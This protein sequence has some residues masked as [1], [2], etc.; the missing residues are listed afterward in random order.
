[1][2]PSRTLARPSASAARPAVE[3]HQRA[4]SRRR[5][6][7]L[8]G[9]VVKNYEG[10]GAFVLFTALLFA[11]NIGTLAVLVAA[12]VSAGLL[13]AEP[14]LTVEAL[15]DRWPMLLIGLLAV[16]SVFWSQ[17]P[18][19]TLKYSVQA[20]LVL[21][22]G[23][24]LSHSP[25]RDSA[26][27]GT[28]ASFAIY[29]A[30]ALTFGRSVKVG[31]GGEMAFSGLTGS[32]NF[33]A[34]MSVLSMLTSLYM[35]FAPRA[36]PAA[37][38]LKIAAG[39]SFLLAL[40]ALVG[41]HSAGALVGGVAAV[42]L[43]VGL[44]AVSTLGFGARLTAVIAA[45][46]VGALLVTFREAAIAALTDFFATAFHKDST[47]TGRTYL[48]YRAQSIIA[49]RPMLGVGFAAF[50]V[51]G[52]ADPEG[53]WRYT[54]VA[55]RSGITFHNTYI[56]YLVELGLVGLVTFLIGAVTGAVGTLRRYVTEGGAAACFWIVLLEY[57]FARSPIEAVGLEPL[58]FTTVLLYAALGSGFG[59]RSLRGPA[60]VRTARF[61]R[62]A[63]RRPESAPQSSADAR[64]RVRPLR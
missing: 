14:R 52:D 37:P 45:L 30:F 35:L 6:A 18:D 19:E 20:L 43:L 36:G 25:G 62:A 11:P 24:R 13:A 53:L 60:R 5:W 39:I 41:A 48:W 26:L 34:D 46:V 23:L 8:I 15:R 2:R 16:I 28:F 38:L 49:A 55:S 50:W 4:N 21:V 56:N 31:N 42:A 40:A 59:M 17:H 54:F 1:M 47:L 58:G 57:Q 27:V 22:V 12:L 29:I 7:R 51:Q 44:M 9:E 33:M 63:R 32:K 3:R 10:I 64:P 61:G